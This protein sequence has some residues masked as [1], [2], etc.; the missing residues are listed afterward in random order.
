MLIDN[1]NMK[2]PHQR[3][4]IHGIFSH[5]PLLFQKQCTCCKH[6]FVR[7]SMWTF[8]GGPWHGGSGTKY[9]LCKE[10]VPT[11]KQAHDYANSLFTQR[12][13]SKVLDRPFVPPPSPIQKKTQ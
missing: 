9:Y 2:L 7:E 3:K 8:V 5:F 12:I 13:M 11:R 6:D 4:Y 1:V 10:C